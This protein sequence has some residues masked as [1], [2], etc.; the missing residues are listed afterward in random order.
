M[1][2]HELASTALGSA[3]VWAA[4]ALG[5][6]G[7]FGHCLAMCGPFVAGASLASGARGSAPVSSGGAS[8]SSRRAAG[9]PVLFQVTYHAGRLITYGLIGA[10]LGLLGQ[11]GALSTLEGPLSP[12]SLTRYLKLGAGLVTIA[13]GFVLLAGWL[14]K[15]GVR[16]PEPTAALAS[17][18]W[19][20]SATSRFAAPK[21]GIGL[22]LGMLMGLLPCAPLLPVELTALAS[23]WPLYGA[24]IMLAFGL[25]TVPALV[26]LG[27]ASGVV[28]ARAR[29]WLGG[30]TAVAVIALGMV[31]VLQGVPALGL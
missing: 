5:L 7:G 26:G 21:S 14:R 2:G 24:L 22:P 25:G 12:V 6:T 20:R 13:V 9:R 29:G 19:F 31:T 17:T 1:H 3:S 10:F 18:A 8:G 11:A 23:G 15:R 28:G 27:V 4:F 16:L 30:L